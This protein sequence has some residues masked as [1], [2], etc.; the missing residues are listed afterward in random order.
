MKKRIVFVNLHSDWMLLIGS[1]VYIFKFSPAVKHGYLLK[2]LLDSPEYEVATV[3]NDRAFSIFDKGGDILQK[4]LRPLARME[5]S[6]IIKKNGIDKHKVKLLKSFG[7]IRHDDIVIVYNLLSNEYRQLENVD[8][9]KVVSMMHFHGNSTD[10]TKILKAGIHQIFNEVDLQKCCELYRRYYPINLPFITVPFVFEDRFQPLKS[11]KCRKNKA[12]SVGTITY[13]IHKEFIETY[14]NPCD[15]PIR[16]A[17]YRDQ[18][19]FQNVADCYNMPYN[20]EEENRKTIRPDDNP[21]KVIYKKIYNRF[22]TGRQKKYFSFDMVEMFNEYKM[23]VVGEEILGIPGIGYVEGMACGSAY[24]GIDSPM[25]R[26]VGLIPGVHYI[27]YDGTKEGLRD[28]IEYW[29]RP[30][31]QD[32][33]EKIASAGCNFVR[34]H[35]NGEKVASYLMSKLVDARDRWLAQDNV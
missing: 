28:T 25:Y 2:Y 12:F 20:E 6:Y 30:E 17:V 3:L 15:Q 13:K 4:L 32:E 26:D 14:G 23:H 16:D 18:A 8:A 10:A 35:F 5:H 21:I 1:M 7:E 31:N 11:F 19:Y 29:Q 22:S 27:S 24:I 9:F 33:L 34:N